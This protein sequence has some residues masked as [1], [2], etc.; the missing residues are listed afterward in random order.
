M[1][2]ILALSVVGLLATRAHEQRDRDAGRQGGSSIEHEAR[3]TQMLEQNNDPRFV[4]YLGVIKD[5]LRKPLSY[6]S[7]AYDRALTKNVDVSPEVQITAK[8][9]KVNPETL[10]A[11]LAS[12]TPREPNRLRALPAEPLSES[13]VNA[14][15]RL[16]LALQQVGK[17]DAEAES[18]CE[19]RDAGGRRRE[20]VAMCRRQMT[21]P[22]LRREYDS[23]ILERSSLQHC[24]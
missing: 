22:V 2:M 1:K 6:V 4:A 9:C 13:A 11:S 5:R 17:M 24:F 3:Q 12:L 10:T 7:A 14:Q 21:T 19:E 15:D 23:R 18:G 16:A 20:E 8:E